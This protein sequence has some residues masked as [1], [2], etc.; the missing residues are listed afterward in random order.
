VSDTFLPEIA[1]YDCFSCHHPLDKPRWSRSRAGAGI[2][3]GTLRLQKYHLLMVEVITEAL[4]PDALPELA[5]ATDALMHA[6]QTDQ[7]AMRSEAQKLHAWIDAHDAWTRRPYTREE[8]EKVRKIIVRYAADDKT[9]DFGAAEQVVMGVDSLSY[10]CGDHERRKTALDA[11][12]NATK[13]AS[14]Y[15]PTQ[16]STVARGL[17]AQ[18]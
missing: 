13:S 6:G 15:D 16:F 1:L 8:V 14:S 12:Y 10:A 4:Q 3:P 17:L 9:S 11:L 7:A 2:P 18:F 5:S